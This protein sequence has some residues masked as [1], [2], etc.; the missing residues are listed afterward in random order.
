VR[1]QGLRHENLWRLHVL[2][3]IVRRGIDARGCVKGVDEGSFDVVYGEGRHLQ[4]EAHVAPQL[5]EGDVYMQ[6]IAHHA[7]DR[8]LPLPYHQGRHA[9]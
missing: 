7:Y 4:I 6:R 2:W 5:A 9:I 8:F 1:A 3:A